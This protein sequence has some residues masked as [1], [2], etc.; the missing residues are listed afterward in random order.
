MLHVAWCMLSVA[1]CLVHSACCLAWCVVHVA[2]SIL[3]VAFACC[4]VHVARSML[5]VACRMPGNAAASSAAQRRR[6]ARLQSGRDERCPSAVCLDMSFPRCTA[7]HVAQY[8][9]RRRS[10]PRRHNGEPAVNHWR[11]SSSAPPLSEVAVSSRP[12]VSPNELRYRGA[13]P[14]RRGAAYGHRAS[15]LWGL[16]SVAPRQPMRWRSSSG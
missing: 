9:A 7:S 1:S 13:Y 16:G 6:K 12:G 8:P 11:K 2:R 15:L 14:R 4:V 10:I 5:H 3:H